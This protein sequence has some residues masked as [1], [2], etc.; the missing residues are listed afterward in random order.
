MLDMQPEP[1]GQRLILLIDWDSL[2]TIKV[3]NK[4]FTGLT[5]GAVRS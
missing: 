1:K 5:K 3:R 4:I 2:K